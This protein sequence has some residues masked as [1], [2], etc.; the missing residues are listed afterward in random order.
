MSDIATLVAL[1]ELIDSNVEKFH[2]GKNKKMC[3]KEKR[4]VILQQYHKRVKDRRS[5][6]I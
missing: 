4:E 6:W 5:S 1:H 2:K 3:E